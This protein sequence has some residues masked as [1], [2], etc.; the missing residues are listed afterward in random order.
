MGSD[1]REIRI[2]FTVTDIVDRL[3]RSRMMSGI[4]GKDTKPELIVRR[5]LH[6]R[7]YRY[8]L[9]DNTLPGKPDVVFPKYKAIIEVHGCFWHKH[10]CHIFKWPKSKQEFWKAKILG[11]VA[12][13]QKNIAKLNTKGWRVLVPEFDTRSLKSINFLPSSLYKSGTWLDFS[14]ESL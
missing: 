8:K 13:D 4:K 7:G 3:T 6:K 14:R 5:E 12:R 2:G 9:H 11:N 10:D 1:P